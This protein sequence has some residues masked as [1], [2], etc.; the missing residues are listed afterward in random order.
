M[1]VVSILNSRN[2]HVSAA[3]RA[4]GCAAVDSSGA[5]ANWKE[6]D[7]CAAIRDQLDFT[8]NQEAR[9]CGVT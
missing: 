7:L 4:T 2:R 6:R 8:K 5:D 3:N 1:D 9:N